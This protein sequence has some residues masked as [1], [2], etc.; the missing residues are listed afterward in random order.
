MPF[1]FL[2]FRVYQQA[3]SFYKAIHAVTLVFPKHQL[4]VL[5]SQLRRAALSIVL[6]IAE[7]SDRGS[8]K[9]FR[10]FLMTALG[11]LNEVVAGLDIALLNGYIDQ[12]EFDKLIS[13]ATYLSNQL[14]SFT[15]ILKEK[16]K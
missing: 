4:F 9:D 7:G 11:S 12:K 13:I 10:H 2:E 1:R 3:R 14:G 6:N 16:S 8:D 15:K 5:A